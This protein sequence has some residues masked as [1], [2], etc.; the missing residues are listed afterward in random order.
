MNCGEVLKYIEERYPGF[1]IL[2]KKTLFCRNSSIFMLDLC[3]GQIRDRI[4]VKISRN[5]QPRE[6]ALEYANLSRFYSGCKD[7]FISSPQPLFVDAENG[8]LAMSHV[9]GTNLS[10]MLHEIRPA[11]SQYLSSAAD[12]SGIALARYHALFCRG[13]GETLTIDT[14][15]RED[16]INQFLAESRERMAECNLK[17]MVT[18]F[19][20][21]TSWNILIKDDNLLN[22]GTKRSMRLFLIDFPRRDY[23]CTPHLDLAR[24]RFG[25]EL[26]KQFPPAKFFGLNRWDVDSLY[27]RFL[28]SYCR[29][30]HVA[31]NQDDLWLIARARKAYIRRA[32]D[33]TRKGRCGWQ[34]KLERMYLQTFSRDWLEQGDIFS[35]WPRM[36]LVEKA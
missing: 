16:D 17:A 6:V 11:S 23:V 7:E 33:L 32:Q 10:Y 26:I 14:N 3:K 15:A 34:P 20:D 8:V 13:E 9:Q 18:P 5:Y 36:G 35:K 30:M 31:L 28:S 12:L 25:L 21:F 19:F 1:K 27:Y 2:G 22:V 24:F 4:V 29:E